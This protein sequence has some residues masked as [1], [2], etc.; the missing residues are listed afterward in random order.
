MTAALHAVTLPLPE[1]TD[2][3]SVLGPDDFVF[4]RNG[5]GLIAAGVAER[6]P[7]ERVGGRLGTIESDDRVG[8]RGTGPI[9]VGA[10]PFDRVDATLRIPRRI[11]GVDH[12]GA[13]I[14][15]IYGGEAQEPDHIEPPAIDRVM[16]RAGWDAAVATILE[17][18]EAGDV[19][20]VVLSRRAIVEARGIIDPVGVIR[21]LAASRPD[22]WVYADTGFVGVT[23]ELLIARDG[24][25]VRSLPM[26]GTLSI[27]LAHEIPKTPRLV[28]E[29]RV[30]VDTIADVLQ[31]CCDDLHVSKPTPTPAGN[32][33]HLSSE[34][35]G[36]LTDPSRTA[37]DLAMT[38]HPTP[39]VGGT[40]LVEALELIEK[41]EPTP[42][43]RYAGPVGWVDAAGDGEFAVAL[44]CAEISGNR[45]VLYA[46]N[47]IVAGSDPAEEWAEAVAKLV[48]MRRVLE[49]SV[50]SGVA[51]F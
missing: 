21:Q 20:K 23:P 13:W 3:L 4:K 45:A 18:I 46:G 1:D 22:A 2:L 35:T 51:A 31:G 24:D 27:D 37:L 49:S 38:L 29:F 17:H 39:A 8:R 30:V 40:P 48:A 5:V 34:V 44:R 36:R 9:A 32:V 12:D 25:R 50:S 28:H 11:I 41:L 42:R 10:I 14:T 47:G 16:G 43:G 15:Q 26:A 6:I 33:A 19:E 7:L